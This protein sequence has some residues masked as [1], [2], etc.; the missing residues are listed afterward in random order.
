MPV[1]DNNW[2]DMMKNVV[3]ISSNL[4]YS[5]NLSSYNFQNVYFLDEMLDSHFD[6]WQDEVVNF[7]F[8][9]KYAVYQAWANF[10]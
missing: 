9:N 6:D 5:K 3:E 8:N 10:Y 1:S 4:S 2:S 7:E